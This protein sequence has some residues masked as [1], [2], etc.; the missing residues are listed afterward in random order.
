M[1]DNTVSMAS[2]LLW[3]F[4]A[5][6]P[7]SPTLVLYLSL[8]LMDFNAW[9]IS[10]PLQPF[11][12]VDSPRHD[13]KFLVSIFVIGMGAPLRYSPSSGRQDPR[14]VPLMGWYK[15]RFRFRA[16]ALATAILTANR[17]L[18]PSFLCCWFHPV[19]SSWR[20]YRFGPATSQ[21]SRLSASEVFGIS[22]PL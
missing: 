15:G 4:S 21:P 22:L 5:K 8:L 18:A 3:I 1:A 10:T 9:K 19:R 11:A 14:I 6:P 20:R 12:E 17:A 7:S 16:A 13:H 2:S